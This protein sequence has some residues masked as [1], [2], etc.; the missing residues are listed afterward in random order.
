[1]YQQQQQQNEE[2]TDIPIEQLGINPQ[3][4][5][6]PIDNNYV[7]ELAD[8]DE[9]E[10]EPIEVRLWP[11][12][13]AKPA[14]GVIYHVVSGN[15][16]TKAA[17]LKGCSTI[18]GKIIDCPDHLSYLLAAIRTNA[19][20]GRN[21][22]TDERRVLA[23]RLSDL[24]QSYSQIA[25]AIGVSKATISG[26]ITG[27]DSN[28]SKKLKVSEPESNLPDE[29][30]ELNEAS[31]LDL[32]FLEL[33][34]SPKPTLS[35][36]V[37]YGESNVIVAYARDILKANHPMTVR[38]VYYQLVARQVI[39]NCEAKYKKVSKL[40]VI[41]RKKEIIPWTWIEDRTRI[42]RRV[43]MWENVAGFADTVRRAYRRDVWNDQSLYMEVW[44]EKDALSGFFEDVLDEYGVTLSVGRG[45][46]SWSSVYEA[47]ERLSYW[48][49][50]GIPIVMLCFGDYDPSGKD[51]VR[52]LQE[53]MTFFRCYPTFVKAALTKEQIIEHRLPHDYAKPQDPRYAKHV[54][55]FGNMAVE[56]DAL[57]TDVLIQLLRKSVEDTMSMSALEATQ[58][59]EAVD[60]RRIVQV[61][62]DVA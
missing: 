58:A 18:R 53:R 50:A 47:S 41:A 16:R 21:F 13:W 20:H 11:D 46:D 28:A 6:R 34:G 19:R 17:W 39:E 42:P 40:L 12:N 1:M 33:F 29:D 27:N 3:Y 7:K 36:S 35:V 52:S 30:S 32:T 43:S 59:Q 45:Y 57:P 26:W 56:L 25:Q 5:A 9:S 61:L 38:Q 10:W 37:G 48:S 44:C 22:S 8:T 54:A 23:K 60:R 51:I 14:L 49:N 2:Y 55:E 24:G 62:K 4:L 15:H 31:I